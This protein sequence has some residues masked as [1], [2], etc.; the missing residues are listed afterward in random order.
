MMLRTSIL[1]F[2]LLTA[3]AI[4]FAADRAAAQAPPPPP[5]TALRNRRSHRRR[6][7]RRPCPRP[8][9][10]VPASPSRRAESEAEITTYRSSSPSAISP[11]PRRQRKRSSPCLSPSPRWDASA[12]RPMPSALASPAW[13]G[14]DSTSMHGP[15]LSKAI[16]FCWS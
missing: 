10:P 5:P 11:A 6:S 7:D 2:F 4:V 8:Q 16:A 13:W 15:A 14:R 9:R 3:G 12:R 1:M